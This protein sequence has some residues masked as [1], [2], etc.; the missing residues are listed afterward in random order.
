[1]AEA[2]ITLAQLA[3]SGRHVVAQC[4]ECPNRA[5]V[6][7]LDIGLPPETTMAELTRAAGAGRSPLYC[8]TC[9][10]RSVLTYAESNRDA[11]QG[12]VR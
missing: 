6:K 9:K 11:R 12:R 1:M 4:G 3:S 10:S 7:P 5:L 2:G 8:S